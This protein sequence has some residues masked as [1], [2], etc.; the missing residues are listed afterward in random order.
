M[1]RWLVFL[2]AVL[3]LASSAFSQDAT[4]A[5]GRFVAM[6]PH[7]YFASTRPPAGQLAQWN[8]AWVHKNVR[9]PL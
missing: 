6:K 4:K 5:R 8:G 1:N 7:S 2:V 9:Y 3:C